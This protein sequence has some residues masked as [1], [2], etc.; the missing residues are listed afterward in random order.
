MTFATGIYRIRADFSG[1]TIHNPGFVTMI[2]TV[3]AKPVPNIDLVSS[4]NPSDHGDDIYFGVDM[5]DNLPDSPPAEQTPLPTGTVAISHNGAPYDTVT[6]G[7]DGEAYTVHNS[8]FPSGHNQMR[9]HYNGDSNWDET[10]TTLDQIVKADAV[11]IMDIQPEP[12]QV[13]LQFIIYI[14]VRASANGMPTPTGEVGRT[15]QR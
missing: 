13:E 1:D 10:E 2:E 3:T 6:L 12:V 4:K 8:N 7:S 11:L 5:S 14:T 15:L 9:A